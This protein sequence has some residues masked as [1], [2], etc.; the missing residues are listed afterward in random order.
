[1]STIVTLVFGI[2]CIAG[3]LIGY[4]KASSTASL[5]AGGLSGVLLIACSYGMR[6]GS[7]A[8]VVAALAVAVLLGL[9]FLGTFMRNHRVMPDLIMIVLSLAAVLAIVLSLFRK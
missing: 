5:I 9:R 4:F 2:F 6:Q 7:R 8:A 3:G 1:M